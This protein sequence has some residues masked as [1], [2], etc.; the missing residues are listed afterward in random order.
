M[1]TKNTTTPPRG[2]NEMHYSFNEKEKDSSLEHYNW[3]KANVSNNKVFSRSQSITLQDFQ[4]QETKTYDPFRTQQNSQIKENHLDY[5]SRKSL[6]QTP[7]TRNAFMQN[8]LKPPL[9]QVYSV[10]KKE[11][12]RIELSSNKNYGKFSRVYE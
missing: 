2:F 7:S 10:K 9:S 12:E 1:K 11:N 4:F 5:D 8:D 6:S 3:R